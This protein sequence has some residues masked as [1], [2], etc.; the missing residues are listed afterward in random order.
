MAK[1]RDYRSADLDA[2]YRVCLETGDAGKDATPIYADPKVIGHVYAGP[3]ATLSPD[4]ALVVEDGEGVGGYIIGSLDTHEFEAQQERDWWPRLRGEY[5]DPSGKPPEDWSPD[6][7]L[8]YL[9][10]HPSRTPR[11]ISGRFPS[12]LHIDLLPRFQRRGIGRKLMDAWLARVRELGSPGAHLGVG[13]RNERAIRFYQSYGLREL[14]R[15]DAP[16]NVVYF[17]VGFSE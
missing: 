11:R 2:L 9:I 8:H 3:Y 10:H 6:E 15:F 7:R 1:I 13:M 16:Y 17:G 12:H 4:T 14:E 5:A